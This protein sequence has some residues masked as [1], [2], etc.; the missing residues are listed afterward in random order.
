MRRLGSIAPLSDGCCKVESGVVDREVADPVAVFLDNYDRTLG[1][2]VLDAR[3]DVEDR[4]DAFSDRVT[5]AA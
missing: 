3:Q 5:H 1:Q 4:S 2:F